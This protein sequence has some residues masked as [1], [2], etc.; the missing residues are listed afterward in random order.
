MGWESRVGVVAPGRF[1]D[2]V[3]LPAD[4][5]VDVDVLC[6]PLAVI[7]GGVPVD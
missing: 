2:L 1:A 3:A 7:K 4:P 6:R 5:L